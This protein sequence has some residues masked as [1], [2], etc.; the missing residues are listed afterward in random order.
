MRRSTA[1]RNAPKVIRRHVPLQ[2][3]E[4]RYPDCKAGKKRRQVSNQTHVSTSD[5]DATLVS[6]PATYRKLYYKAHY[7]VDAESRVILDC[8][9]TT[10]A[11]HECTVMPKCLAPL[12]DDGHWPI[13]EVLADKAYGR[14][15]TSHF[16]RQQTLRAYIP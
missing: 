9:L 16:L 8:H 11:Q 2:M 1:W 4:Q 15:L 5:P 10:G 6:R 3:Y 13:E 12:L 7:T 14:G